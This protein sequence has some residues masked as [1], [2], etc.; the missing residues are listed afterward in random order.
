MLVV[1]IFLLLV[2]LALAIPTRSHPPHPNVSVSQIYQF[3]E[4]DHW[5]ENLVVRSNGMI[6]AT[7]L[8]AAKLWHIDPS[9]G[10]IYLVHDFPEYLGLLGIVEYQPDVFA[11]IAGNFSIV[12]GFKS[13]PGTYSIWS[14]DFNCGTKVTK[15]ADVPGA[16]FLNGMAYLESDDTLLLADSDLGVIWSLSLKTRV[17][18]IGISDPLM[19][20]VTLD[21]PDGING[22]KVYGHELWFT[23]GFVALVARIPISNKGIALGPAEIVGTGLNSTWT[24]DDLVV[25]SKGQAYNAIPFQNLIAR[26]DGSGGPPIVIA[27]NLNSTEIAEPTSLAFGRSG[28][29][30]VDE[31]VL[32][33][34][35]GGAIA[36]PIDGNITVGGQIIK[37]QLN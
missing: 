21:A 18:T 10:G 2:T 25:N 29:G 16:G 20:K 27:G 6:L 36:D 13:Y 23:R 14:V 33:V 4:K 22:L 11:F 19:Q 31:H 35:T 12:E 28:N 15:I 7:E 34:A 30:T 26:Y 1:Q 37:I 17:S 32:Y 9:D 5:F 8:T 3:P 24:M